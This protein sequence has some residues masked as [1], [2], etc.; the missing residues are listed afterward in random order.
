M[1]QL[2][3]FA[4]VA[5]ALLMGMTSCQKEESTDTPKNILVCQSP[6]FLKE[7]DTVALISPSYYTPMENV[8]KAATIIREWGYVPVIGKNVGKIH[9]GNYAGTMEE[10]ME[11]LIWAFEDPSV[12]AIICNRGGYGS[13]Q[14]V[15]KVPLSLF[16]QNPK[17]F[18]GFSDITTFHTM[19]SHAGVMSLLGPSGNFLGSHNPSL[20]NTLVHNILSGTIPMYE[21]PAHPQNIV[22]TAS[23]TLV[24]G[25]LI[26]FTQLDGSSLDITGNDDIILFLEEIGE[27]WE[28]IDRQ[29]NILMLSG[30]LSRCKGVILGE[31]T[32][33]E[34]NLDYESIEAMLRPYFEQY[35]I[36]LMCGFPE[37]HDDVNM[38][39]VMGAQVTMD[40]RPT[41]ATLS[42]H[43]NRE[44]EIVVRS[45]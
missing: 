8:E 38:P 39:L 32:D 26:T 24:G 15:D 22:G 25:N 23:G 31:F 29:V 43:M 12:K 37:G 20:S 33:C 19:L 5:W 16:A 34:K 1:K 7:G 6:A 2:F 9:A 44:Q 36:P 42:F 45:E 17:W 40:V 27:L 28:N 18:V 30:V 4:L 21:I 14:F 10:R 35:G 41:G 11:D 3:K 13:I